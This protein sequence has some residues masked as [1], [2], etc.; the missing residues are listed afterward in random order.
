MDAKA[1]QEMTEKR[2]LAFI[3]EEDAAQCGWCL[4]ALGRR[5]RTLRSAC[6]YCPVIEVFGESCFNLDVY[7]AWAATGSGEAAQDIY[8][9]LMAH[10]EQLI[11]AGEA[12][13]ETICV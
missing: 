6:Y 4:F 10:R 11:A 2:W 7:D 12:M 9:L 8:D 13:D 1:A 3:N 5:S